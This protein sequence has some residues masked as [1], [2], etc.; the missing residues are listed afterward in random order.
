LSAGKTHEASEN[1]YNTTSYA[2]RFSS[3]G[4][5]LQFACADGIT[6]IPYT[7]VCDFRPDCKD[8]SDEVFCKHPPCINAFTCLSGQCVSYVNRGNLISDCFDDSDEIMDEP[9]S[10]YEF[11]PTFEDSG[12]TLS[13]I[14]Q[15]N[16][17][18]FFT[19][20][21]LGSED[22]CPDTHYRCPGPVT[23]CMPVYT[24]CNGWF[25][26]E[27]RQDED[28]C[29][30]YQCPGFYR[31]LDSQVCVHPDHLC[32]GW[33]QCP[34][35][36]DEWLCEENPCPDGCMCQGL[37]FVCV[38]PFPSHLHPQLRYLDG[39]GSGISPA[40]LHFNMYLIHLVLTRCQLIENDL[41]QMNN[42][43]LKFL[44]LSKNLIEAVNTSVFLQLSNLQT[45]LM[46][47]NPLTTIHSGEPS[48]Q[49]IS[50]QNL[51]LSNTKLSTFSSKPWEAFPVITTLNL[52]FTPLKEFTIEG[53]KQLTFLKEL[54]VTS[55]PLQY[56]QTDVFHGLS[57]LKTVNA[58]NY[59]LCCSAVLPS[60]MDQ[61]S[62]HA[63]EDEVSSCDDLLRS[64][65]YRVFSW[66]ICCLSVTGNIFCLVFR[67][68]VQR[69]AG[70]SAFNLFVS[71][72]CVADLL[73]GIYT[74]MI[75][76]ADA[77]SRGQYIIFERDWV[78]SK[79][80][81]AAGFF[82]LLS[83]EVSA[84][85]I[86]L[87]TLDRFIVLRF[88]FSTMRINKTSA[89]VTCVAIWVIGLTLAVVPLLPVTSHWEFYSQSGICIPL[90]VTRRKFEG[91]AYSTGIVIFLNFI[92]FILIV[93]G[94]G[95]VFWSVQQNAMSTNTT[96][97][98][99]DLTVARRLITV[100]LTDFL[101]WFPIGFCGILAWSG[102][103][104]PGEVS[105]ALAM[106]VLP[107][108]AALNPFLYTFNIIM[109]KRRK[110]QMEKMVNRIKSALAD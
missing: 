93:A 78:T 14:I 69:T 44:D 47:G 55:N 101:C 7:L 66:L 70:K 51:D 2:T 75:G 68:C 11:K 106:L 23:I 99:H 109:E 98:S 108:N 25:D 60:H 26:C 6:Y 5:V 27:G 34:Q 89:A 41:V 8:H 105:V 110:A 9:Y 43:N 50:L 15:Y 13:Y 104:I 84:L 53:L 102:V 81:K 88:P 65:L 3:P 48:M 73:M 46:S 24:R 107:I 91:Q 22:S 57:R 36:D 74:A 97:K 58:D 42:A 38:L 10:T 63:I 45:I 64:G 35:R 16:A 30:S 37:A 1:Q 83:C 67:S 54:D 40:S 87:I 90:P 100:A 80:C 33:P 20:E 92:L 56:F 12:V 18:G 61:H 62:C 49:Q 94:Q 77:V 103:A 79:A 28:G 76:A 71:S 19:K 85:T 59:K 32:D 4:L 95:F 29:D 72:L 39:S 82:S 52:S 17:Q 21:E 86:L 31:C 96:R